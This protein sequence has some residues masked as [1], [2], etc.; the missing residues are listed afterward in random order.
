MLSR[1]KNKPD[2]PFARSSSALS[3][4]ILPWNQLNISP[5]VSSNGVERERFMFQVMLNV[6]GLILSGGASSSVEKGEQ[7][8]H[9]KFV[10]W[11]E[12]F[13]KLNSASA[14]TGF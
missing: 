2:D 5:I 4:G 14:N 1:T 13:I 8:A 12:E 9:S 11:A 6:E 10:G 7:K 3:R